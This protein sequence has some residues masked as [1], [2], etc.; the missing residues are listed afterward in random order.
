MWRVQVRHRNLGYAGVALLA[1]L[2][3]VGMVLQLPVLMLAGGLG[4]VAL[5]CMLQAGLLDGD[6]VA[7]CLHMLYGRP[8]SRV[9]LAI[10]DTMSNR[11]SASS[12]IDRSMQQALRLYRSLNHNRIY[13]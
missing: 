7:V 8:L 3:S 9:E 13:R 6:L 10:L 1:A 11:C 5:F 2:C 4:S 12:P